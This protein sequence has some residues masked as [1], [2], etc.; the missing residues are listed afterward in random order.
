MSL[1]SRQRGQMIVALKQVWIA[2]N[3]PFVDDA[4]LKRLTDAS[5]TDLCQFWAWK[6][7]H[8]VGEDGDLAR[9]PLY[10]P[11][12]DFNPAGLNNP[13]PRE[14]RQLCSG[15]AANPKHRAYFN[16]G[17]G[18]LVERM[19]VKLGETLTQKQ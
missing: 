8:W 14:G 4:I 6:N 10:H 17:G 19:R 1:S 18:E 15:G 11:P 5:L 7:R 2:R 9:Q 12:S 16:A 3:I 13:K